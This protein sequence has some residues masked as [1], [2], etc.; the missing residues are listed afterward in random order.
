[1]PTSYI[2]DTQDAGVVKL[3]TRVGRTFICHEIREDGKH[4]L[5]AGSQLSDW[6]QYDQIARAGQFAATTEHYVGELPAV[7]YVQVVASHGS[8]HRANSSTEGS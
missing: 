8:L 6:C 3:T 1:M 4:R 2:P 7:F 5:R